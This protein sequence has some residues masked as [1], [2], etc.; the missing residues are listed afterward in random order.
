MQDLHTRQDRQINI[1]EAIISGILSARIRPGTRL[2]ENQL[3]GLF[4][5]S[6][7]RVREAMM[8]LETRGIVHVSARRGWFVVE[9][10]AEEAMTIYEARRII[11]SGLLRSMRVL[12]EEGRKVLLAH[13]EEER[14][15]IAAADRQRLTCLLG[16]FH[17]RIAELC[18][19]AVLIELLRDLTARTILISM[20]YQ[21][22]FHALQSHEG[23]CRIFEAMAAGDFV[24]AAE[25]SIEHLDEVETG[26]DLTRRPDPLAGLRRSLALPEINGGDPDK[27]PTQQKSSKGE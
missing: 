9:P 13:L 24:K 14:I 8:R 18:G 1:E 23:H 7:T 21:S 3:A 10:S 4:S 27:I 17:I 26:L 25:L 16:D 19:N 20:L 5:V 2:S 11:E 12:S 15:A 22:E 6:R